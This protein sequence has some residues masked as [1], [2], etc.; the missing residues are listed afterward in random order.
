MR[1]NHGKE[2]II[3]GGSFGWRFFDHRYKRV[4]TDL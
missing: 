1:S 3:T 2:K 4:Y